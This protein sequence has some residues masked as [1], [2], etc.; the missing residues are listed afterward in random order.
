MT[1]MGKSLTNLGVGVGILV[2]LVLPQTLLAQPVPS[3]YLLSLLSVGSASAL[4]GIS[5]AHALA[6]WSAIILWF[7]AAL[8]PLLSRAIDSFGF[9][10]IPFD[11]VE[12]LPAV[13][14][15]VAGLSVRTLE[16][17]TGERRQVHSLLII[18]GCVIA[19]IL[20]PMV[21]GEMLWGLCLNQFQ[22]CSPPKLLIVE[23][24]GHVAL[25]GQVNVLEYNP[26]FPD[27]QRVRAKLDL[28]ELGEV[29]GL[30]TFGSDLRI[31]AVRVSPGSADIELSSYLITDGR[32]ERLY[33][34]DLSEELRSSPNRLSPSGKYVALDNDVT[35]LADQAELSPETSPISSTFIHWVQNADTETAVFVSDAQDSIHIHLVQPEGLSEGTMLPSQFSNWPQI[36]V[37]PDLRQVA[38]VTIDGKSLI[39]AD[40]SRSMAEPKSIALAY[41][42]AKDSDLYWLSNGSVAYLSAW[43]IPVVVEVDSGVSRIAGNS[44]SNAAIISTDPVGGSLVW[45]EKESFGQG[46]SYCLMRRRYR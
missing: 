5:A 24:N 23:E 11:V 44:N 16:I 18:F 45:L 46:L 28:S 39:V 25:A 36:R 33:T 38:G 2:L 26:M 19:P 13:A 4:V 40:R 17:G 1:Y 21:R 35:L 9:R 10:S 31:A 29:V 34:M 12:L 27:R 15:L 41:H 22:L 42:K 37:S 43:G 14:V 3:I 32:P 6:P 7:L 30:A 8:I 20:A